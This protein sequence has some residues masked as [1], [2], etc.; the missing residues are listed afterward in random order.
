MFYMA[1]YTRE[2]YKNLE[3][4]TGLSTGYK[5]VGYIEIASSESRLRA[6]R[7]R[8]NFARAFGIDVRE[9]SPNEFK[10]LSEKKRSGNQ[11]ESGNLKQSF[12]QF[13]LEDPEPL[14]YFGEQIYRDG[15]R[16]G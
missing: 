9:I 13:Q 11:K 1:H 16:V 5:S 6:L 4:E 8:A 3:K 10:N 7:N 2:L 15:K 12:L 14:L